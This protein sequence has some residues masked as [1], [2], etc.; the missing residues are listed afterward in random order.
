MLKTTMTM[1][2]LAASLA[3]CGNF[4]GASFC[5]L[6]ERLETDEETARYL[7]KHD[8]ALVVDM[9]VHNRLVD[10]CK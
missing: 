5:D 6:A 9:N 2:C 3:S 8:R 1:I 10:R 7:L 4:G